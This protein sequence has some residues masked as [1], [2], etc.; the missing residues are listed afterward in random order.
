[1]HD[2]DS[3]RERLLQLVGTYQRCAVAFSAGVD[4]TVVAKAAQIA[5]GDRAVAVTGDSPS[6]ADGELAEARRLAELIG[7]RHIVI[8]TDELSNPLYQRNA[9]DRCFHCKTELYQ[10]MA[11]W[12]NREGVGVLVNGANADDMT[13]YRPGA[14]AA[15]QH[16]VRSPLAECDINKQEVRALASGWQLPIWDKPAA[17]CLSSRLAYGQEVTP[18]RLAM[19]DQAEQYVRG[20]GLANVRVRYHE[21]D[22][23]RIEIPA[24]AIPQI[25][26]EE[27]RQGLAS[28]FRDL[29]FKFITLDLE[30]FR[31]GSLNTLLPVEALERY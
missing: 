19:I 28:H 18:E 5:L 27:V 26:R 23:A 10:L 8:S 2:L 7:I 21:G 17:P 1:M 24:E 16:G 12:A 29:G 15:R 9:P 20:Q 31:S 13:D 11:Q 30:G 25:C 4:S 22:M 3:K 6:L 14:E